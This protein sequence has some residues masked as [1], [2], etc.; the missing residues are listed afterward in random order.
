MNKFKVEKSQE[1][2]AEFKE[3][4]TKAYTK[5]DIDDVLF[6]NT[7]SLGHRLL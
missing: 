3:F 7:M 4:A 1:K 5:G 6:Y 2:T